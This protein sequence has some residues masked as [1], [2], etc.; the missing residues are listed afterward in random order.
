MA[1]AQLAQEIVVRRQIAKL[2]GRRIRLNKKGTKLRFPRGIQLEYVKVLREY[3]ETIA[4]AVREILYPSLETLT[5]NFIVDNRFDETDPIDV[6]IQELRNMIDREIDLDSDITEI[7]TKVSVWQRNELQTHIRSRLGVDLLFHEPW[8]KDFIEAARKDNIR[9]IT[10][11]TEEELSNVEGIVR[12][13]FR[14]GRRVEVLR[15][16]ISHQMGVSKSRAYLIA[17]DQVGKINGE[18]NKLRQTNLG[19]DEYDWMTS[20]DGDRVRVCH[21]ERHGKRYRWDQPPEGGDHP[22]IEISCRCIAEPV[23]DHLIQ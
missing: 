18:T 17:R 7:I 13:G 2:N 20:L 1:N 12:S 16:Q 19:I 6:K 23:L 4:K 21:Q 9:L 10:K 14:S 8:L 22:G 3:Q 11:M 15:E 5:P